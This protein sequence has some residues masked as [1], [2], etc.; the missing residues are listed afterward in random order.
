[1][2]EATMKHDGQLEALE[3]RSYR[4]TYSDGIIDIFAGASLGWIGVA[5]IWLQD[6]AG[7]AGVLPAVF[8]SSVLVVRRRFV[9]SRAGYVQ[10]SQPRLLQQRRNLMI[11]LAAGVGL[12]TA[13]IGAF[14]AASQDPDVL[15]SL[16][17]GLLAW[18]LALVAAGLAFLLGTWRMLLYAG[19]LTVAGI[20]T[21]WADANPGW[22]LLACGIVVVVAG[23]ALL[24]RYVRATP[25]V[26]AP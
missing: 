25:P 11:V 9:E 10:W 15:G 5:W 20:A 21:A 13:G 4:A 12:F 26:E 8:V 24:V 2:T 22:P 7:L 6:W 18:L 16:A 23:V 14:V 3:A 1:M 17:P 19:V